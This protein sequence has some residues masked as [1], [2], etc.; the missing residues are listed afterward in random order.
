MGVF[1]GWVEGV[2]NLLEGGVLVVVLGEFG[3]VV[4]VGVIIWINGE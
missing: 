2:G 3:F 1:W 4:E